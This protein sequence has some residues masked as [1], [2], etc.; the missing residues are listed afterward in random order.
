MAEF[1]LA[2][3]GGQV[4][5]GFGG[6]VR[7][8]IGIRDGRIAA[9]AERIAGAAQ[10]LDADGLLVLPGG[11]DSHCHIEE[12]QA[13]GTV[14]EEGFVTASASAF[15]GGTTSV[16]CF[17]PQWKGQGVWER[18]RDYRRRAAGGMLD[19]AFHQIVTDPTDRVVAEEL[20]RVVAEGVRSLKVFLTYEPLHLTDGQFLRVLAAARRLGCLVSVHCENRDAIAWRTAELLRAGLA[21]PKYHAW[22]RPAVVEREATHRAIALAELVDQPIQ[23]FH[24]SCAEVAEEIARAQARGL[25]VW[26]ET[27]PQYL[28]LTAADMDRPGFEGAKFVCSPPPRAREEQARLWEMI[29]RGTL[30]VV[31]SDH[32]GFSY[33]GERGKAAHGRDAP[34]P[35]IPNGIPGLAARMPLLFS[36]GVARG[37]IGLDQFVRLVSTN[38]ARLMGLY[39]RKG[40]I[41]VGSD[42]DLVLWDP[43]RRQRLT[44][45]LMRHA[46]DYTPYEGL[47]V[48]G[49]PVATIRRGVVVMREGKVQAEPGS[50]RFLPRDPYAMIRPRGVVP[51]GFDPAPPPP[52]A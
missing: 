20:P 18:Y 44:N 24:V 14:S 38:P 36:E 17:V 9:L 11:V 12:P 8:D 19:H 40:A 22:S 27:C 1:D 48:I 49:W 16:V 4:A 5:S 39:P 37:R 3:R 50:G 23:V 6:T 25:K 47:E 15:A 45:A 52:L 33:G 13:D 32:C 30:D 31:S 29:R 7:C 26:G 35:D 10:V 41:M 2:V 34:F 42:A 21:A 43:A 51:D 46:I 28:V